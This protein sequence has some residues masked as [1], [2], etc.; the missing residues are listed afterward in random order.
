MSKGKLS[1]REK[2]PEGE[3]SRRMFYTRGLRR[4]RTLLETLSRT[5]GVR[6]SPSEWHA[7]PRPQQPGLKSSE[8][9]HLAT[10]QKRIGRKFDT[11]DQ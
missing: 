10:Q 7:R 5:C 11:V 1:G 8:L 4:N 2:F 3:M 6:M 9:R